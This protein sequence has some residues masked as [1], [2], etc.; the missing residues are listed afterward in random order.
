MRSSPLTYIGVLAFT[1]L[2]LSVTVARSETVTVEVTPNRKACTVVNMPRWKV[3]VMTPGE[4][5]WGEN[6]RFGFQCDLDFRSSD[7]GI[8]VGSYCQPGRF[9][10]RVYSPSRYAISFGSGRIRRAAESEWDHADPYLNF[11]ESPVNPIYALK[12]DAP[13]PY[14]G[15][16][17]AK[18]GS[19]WCEYPQFAGDVSQDGSLLAVNSWDGI[20]AVPELLMPGRRQFDGHYYVDLYDV[21]SGHRI[22]TVKGEFHGVNPHD[23]FIKSAWISKHYFVLPLDGETA[24]RRFVICDVRSPSPDAPSR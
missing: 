9:T 23:L 4:G 1:G 8:Q 15:K 2:L 17:F 6:A 7:G 24:H 19:K 21:A 5:P 14:Q 10:G 18:T 12:D 3:P 22:L 11:R 13:I 16:P 20:I